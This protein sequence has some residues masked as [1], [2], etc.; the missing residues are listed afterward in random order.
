MCVCVKCCPALIFMISFMGSVY[1]SVA[2]AV[3]A[4]FEFYVSPL[5]IHMAPK[6]AVTIVVVV[7]QCS[8]V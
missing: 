1:V 3:S 6:A 7:M 2:V 4:Q 8:T 5:I